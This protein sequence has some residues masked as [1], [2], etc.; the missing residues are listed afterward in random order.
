MQAWGVPI[1]VAFI[2][3]L[4]SYIVVLEESKSRQALAE[5]DRSLT[6]RI[7]T[8]DREIKIL[9][10]FMAGILSR[11]DKNKELAL[12]VLSSTDG[13]IAENLAKAVADSESPDSKL[14][15]LAKEIIKKYKDAGNSFPVVFSSKDELAAKKIC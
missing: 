4:G 12:R 2:G 9:D 5:L 8:E 3:M 6:Q 7:S 14:H 1:S 11:Y 13:K 10:I 15:T